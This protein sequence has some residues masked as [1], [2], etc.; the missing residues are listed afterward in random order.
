[1]LRGSGRGPEFIVLAQSEGLLHPGRGVNAKDSIS[2]N[3]SAIRIESTSAGTRDS[4]KRI[5]CYACGHFGHVARACTMTDGSGWRISSGS[6]PRVHGSSP[7]GPRHSATSY[8][9]FQL[10]FERL[11]NLPGFMQRQPPSSFFAYDTY[12]K[13]LEAK[14]QNS[15]AMAPEFIN[16]KSL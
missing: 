9:P 8:I 15:Y 11:S 7:A 10:L 12:V 2:D 1:M 16:I 3:R 14:L 6:G 4:G 5:R 13:E